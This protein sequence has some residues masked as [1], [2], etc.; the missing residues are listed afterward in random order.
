MPPLTLGPFAVHPSGVLA[1]RDSGR[2][3]ALRFAWR[4][5][6]CEAE[7]AGD[8]VR[9]AAIAA[10]IPSTAEP[11]A[12]R[13]GALAALAPLAA[14]LPEGWRMRLLPDHRIRLEATSPIGSPPTAVGLITEL[15][16]FALALDPYLDRLEAA[17]AGAPAAMGAPGRTEPGTVKSCPG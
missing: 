8:A 15:V 3:P 7:L 9:I 16:R 6:A 4:G 12:D 2:R 1:P 11:G 10:R 14:G 13:R 5:R 17:G